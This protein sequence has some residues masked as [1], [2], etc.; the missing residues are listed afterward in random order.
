VSS[1]FDLSS[2]FEFFGKG[3]ILLIMIF[4]VTNPVFKPNF[5]LVDEFHVA[6]YPMIR[7]FFVYHR[8]GSISSPSLETDFPR[9]AG[10]PVEPHG[11]EPVAPMLRRNPLRLQSS[12]AKA[13]EDTRIP[14]RSGDRGFLRRRVIK[15]E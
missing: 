5:G 11:Q 4:I 13:S 12:F 7:I 9:Q 6:P 3:D 14:P 10:P 8:R 1:T 15:L 2:V